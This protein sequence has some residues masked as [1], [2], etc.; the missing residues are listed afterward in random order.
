[1]KITLYNAVIENIKTLI[2]DKKNET[3]GNINKER[4]LNYLCK[5]DNFIFFDLLKNEIQNF[6]PEENEFK[7]F[8][9]KLMSGA[10]MDIRKTPYIKNSEI[11]EYF[12]NVLEKLEK[13]GR[14]LGIATETET[15]T[16]TETAPPPPVQSFA[17][18]KPPNLTDK[19][20]KIYETI[21]TIETM[22]NDLKTLI[23][24]D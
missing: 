18:V 4:F 10:N 7:K 5:I 23:L 12:S 20:K 1:M 13:Y 21:K 11:I 3:P 14:Q 9:R 15:E 19:N 16:E 17:N 6:S 8:F 2:A 24:E 22:L